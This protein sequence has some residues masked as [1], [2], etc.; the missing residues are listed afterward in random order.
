MLLEELQRWRTVIR[1]DGY[2]IS[3]G[4]LINLY[5]DGDLLIQP[6]F[7]RLFRW[8]INQ[9]S[10]FIESILLGI[11]I[12]SIFVAA[13]KSGKWELVDGLQRTC[14]IL[15]FIGELKLDGVKQDPSTLEGTKYLPSLK[16]KRW[17]SAAE[18]DPAAFSAD[19]R[20]EFKR[21]KISVEIIEKGSDPFS[22]FE[23]FKRLNTGGAPASPQEVRNCVIVAINPQVFE[24]LH[25][26][27]EDANFVACTELSD[28]ANNEQYD[29]EL[30]CRF[31]SLVWV[32]EPALRQIGDIGVFV[33]GQVEAAATDA[34]YQWD[35]FE[36][37]FRATFALIHEK[38]G[39][40]TFRRFDVERDR[41]TGGFVISMFEAIALGAGYH[42]DNPQLVN[43][44]FQEAVREIAEN[45]DFLR[46]T[47]SGRRASERIPYSIPIGRA[48]FEP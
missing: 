23:L 3:L 25:A 2:S 40:N 17:E 35:E 37:K 5:R 7:Q 32:D 47:G 13:D 19:Q 33:D 16:G 12:P 31:L 48:G 18:D 14:T 4:E 21:A 44:D 41:F 45:Q 43:V 8:D 38:L 34:N 24:R 1:T 46:W 30:V 27:S 15:N 26:L 39:D 20:R 28:R 36:R 29:M 11:P 6:A 9:Q 22:K 42:I 10:K